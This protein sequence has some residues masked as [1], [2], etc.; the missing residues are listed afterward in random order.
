MARRLRRRYPSRHPPQALPCWRTSARAVR[1]SSSTVQRTMPPTCRRCRTSPCSPVAHTEPR[2][3]HAMAC[4]LLTPM[5]LRCVSHRYSPPPTRCSTPSGMRTCVPSTG[6]WRADPTQRAGPAMGI[7]LPRCRCNGSCLLTD[8]MWVYLRPIFTDRSGG[9]A[10]PLDLNHLSWFYWSAP[11]AVPKLLLCDWI[12]KET[13]EAAYGTPWTGGMAAWTWGPEHMV[14]DQRRH[15][16]EAATI[17]PPP[18]H[19]STPPP[20]L[21]SS[22]PPP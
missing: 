6:A 19:S 13:N 4:P 22:P 8:A 2:T 17:C 12:E 11:L 3:S 5:A 18:R 21:P 20:L 16:Y 9:V 14:R 1:G 15:A 10:W 7:P